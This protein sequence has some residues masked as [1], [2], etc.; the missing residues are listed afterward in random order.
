MHARHRDA[1]RG[2]STAPPVD[3]HH[4]VVPP[5]S[6]LRSALLVKT[7][8]RIRNLFLG[9]AHRSCGVS[10]F[11]PAGPKKSSRGRCPSVTPSRTRNKVQRPPTAIVISKEPWPSAAG[12]VYTV[13]KIFEPCA[14]RP[15]AT[16]SGTLSTCV[17]QR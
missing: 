1:R 12:H 14:D 11:F 8:H 9:R 7:I 2:R 15:A 5:A 4:A 16:T 6:R 13:V 3:P 10:L 17:C